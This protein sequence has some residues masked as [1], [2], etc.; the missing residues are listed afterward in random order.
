MLQKSEN[1]KKR[2]RLQRRRMNCSCVKPETQ[3]ETGLQLGRNRAGNNQRR[4]RQ[5]RG[6]Q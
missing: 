1:V 4:L 2:K 3:R 6:K 5:Q